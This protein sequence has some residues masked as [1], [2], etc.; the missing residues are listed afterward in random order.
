MDVTDLREQVVSDLCGITTARFRQGCRVCT[1][2]VVS[3]ATSSVL[4]PRNPGCVLPRR[5][6]ALLR[7]RLDS[8]GSTLRLWNLTSGRDRSLLGPF[9][10][11]LSLAFSADGKKLAAVGGS[12]AV[13]LLDVASGKELQPE[14]GHDSGVLRIALSP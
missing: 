7:F 3:W 12:T 4:P 14:G 2:V 11:T 1:S 5:Q 8:T 9:E 10:V 13:H 6:R